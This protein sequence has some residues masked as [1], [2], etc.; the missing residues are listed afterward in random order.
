MSDRVDSSEMLMGFRQVAAYRQIIKQIS[1]S[2]NSTL[3][4]GGIMLGFWFMIYTRKGVPNWNTMPLYGYIHLALA[5]GELAVGLWKKLL[6]SPFAFLMDA[7]ILLGFAGANG[8]RAFNQYQ[9]NGNVDTISIAFCAYML[10]LAYREF[11]AWMTIN[12]LLIYRPTRAQLAQFDSLVRD[13]RKA[14][15]ETEPNALDLRTRPGWRALLLGEIAFFVASTGD[16]VVTHR[17]EVEIDS[18][19]DDERHDPDKPKR[20]MLWLVG[21]QFGPFPLDVRSAANYAA[22]KAAK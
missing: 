12:R 6:P 7:V 19:D 13:V 3:I 17:D 2:A 21:G 1:Q 9:Q 8:W 11:Q 20:S 14:N 16:V 10:Y 5:V 15:P 22:W 4:W 18:D